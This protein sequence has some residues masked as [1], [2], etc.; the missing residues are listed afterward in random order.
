MSATAASS[1]GG[2]SK[3]AKGKKPSPEEIAERREERRIAQAEEETLA[4]A[5]RTEAALAKV[6]LDNLP[7][8]MGRPPREMTE[9]DREL[10]CTLLA[11]GVPLTRICET[12]PSLPHISTVWRWI[13]ESP[14]FLAD[15]SRAHES[16][17]DTWF[18]ECLDIADDASQ[19]VNPDGSANNVAV[20]R[21]KLRIDTRLRMIAK[22]APKKYAEH[23]RPDAMQVTN[24]NLTVIDSRELD[25]EQRESLRRMLIMARGDV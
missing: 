13:R 24:N 14:D 12:Q 8:R 3:R 2:E 25:P 4:W 7:A 16:A 6:S 11:E 15:Y 20:Q 1:G 22:I 21:A 23:M 19:D 5:Q 10:I 9:E 18:S 17:A